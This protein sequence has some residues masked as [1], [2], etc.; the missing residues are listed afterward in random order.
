MNRHF[1]LLALMCSTIQPAWSDSS[2]YLEY[3]RNEL[4]DTSSRV[5]LDQQL[6]AEMRLYLGAGNNMVESSLYDQDSHFYKLGIGSNPAQHNASA[7]YEKWTGVDVDMLSLQLRM[8]AVFSPGRIS[9]IPITRQITVHTGSGDIQIDSNAWGIE[10]SAFLSEAMTLSAGQYEY[11]YSRSSPLPMGFRP[12]RDL[13][14]S[15]LLHAS[16]FA[17]RSRFIE[18]SFAEDKSILT[19]GLC[20]ATMYYDNSETSYLY[21]GY[22]YNVT[23]SWVVS[24]QLGRTSMQFADPVDDAMLGLAYQY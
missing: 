1:L 10:A 5:L 2:L 24:L 21:I 16:S 23:S 19:L 15:S 20:E 4:D 14:R 11:D 7:L 12:L 18:T 6:P 17:L 9:L 13:S 8:E 3:Q 22:A